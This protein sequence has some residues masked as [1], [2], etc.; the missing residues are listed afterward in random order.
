MTTL[1][2]TPT[3]NSL[4]PSKS[5]PLTAEMVSSTH[6]D[7]WTKCF[8]STLESTFALNTSCLTHTVHKCLFSRLMK[9]LAPSSSYALKPAKGRGMGGGVHVEEIQDFLTRGGLG[10]QNRDVCETSTHLEMTALVLSWYKLVK[11]QEVVVSAGFFFSFFCCCR[12]LL[13]GPSQW[14]GLELQTAKC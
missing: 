6:T 13:L 7:W 4:D 2:Q 9:R 5:V 14:S 11:K 10:C 12:C 8:I 3:N 1:L